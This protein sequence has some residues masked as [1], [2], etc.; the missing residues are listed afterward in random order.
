[1]NE[2]LQVVKQV[3]S[4]FCMAKLAQ[5]SRG[6]NKHADSLATLTSSTME[7]VPWLIKI[8]LIA[9]P[10]INTAVSVAVISLTEPYW[11]DPII[12]FLAED[13]VPYNEKEANKV[14]RVAAQY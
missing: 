12:D 14:R 13:R 11:I 1:M 8:E 10:R 4:K 7:D 3:M 9:E 5:V 6:Q 2:Y